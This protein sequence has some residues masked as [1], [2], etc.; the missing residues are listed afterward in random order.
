MKDMTTPIHLLISPVSSFGL[1]LQTVFTFAI[2]SLVL[3]PVLSLLGYISTNAAKRPIHTIV[4][5]SVL[6]TTAYFSI[7]DLSI[8]NSINTLSTSFYHDGS[9]TL[10]NASEWVRI[11]NPAEYPDALH[12]ASARLVFAGISSASVPDIPFTTNCEG[13]YEKDLLIPFNQLDSWVDSVSEVKAVSSIESQEDVWRLRK[14]FSWALWVKWNFTRLM[15]LIHATETFDLAVVGIAYLAMHYTFISLYISMQRLGS[16]FWLAT[17]IMLSSTFA[18][19]FAFVTSFYLGVPVSIVTLSEGLPFLVVTIGFGNKIRLTDIVLQTFNTRKPGSS[20][21]D[22]I[23]GVIVTEGKF[24]LRDYAIEI[25]ALIGG[26]SCGV[27]GLWQFCFLSVWI[28]IYD[29]LM[30]VTF[31]SA[32]LS[33]K[34]EIAKI[35]R[36]EA[37]RDALEEDGVS[38]KVAE[39]VAHSQSDEKKSNYSVTVFKVL[40]VS[41]F[42]LLNAVQLTNYP[43]N[44]ATFK[45]PSNSLSESIVRQVPQS[46]GG[47]VVTILPAFI[48]EHARLSARF[49]DSII[50]FLR[51]WTETIGD[52]LI[53]KFVVI[54]LALSVGLNAYLFNAARE[55]TVKIVEKIVEIEKKIPIIIERTSASASDSDENSEDADDMIEMKSSVKSKPPASKR[56][57]DESALFLKAGNA[58][59]LET[60]ELVNLAVSGKLPLY[61]LEKHLGD[62]TRAVAVR[63]AAV[64]RLS[65][66]KNLEN[67]LLPYEH[68]D[69]DRV[70]GACCENVVGYVPIP[71]GVAGPMTIDGKSY[72]LPMATTEGCLVAST[73]RGCKAM[74]AG[75]GVTTVLTNDGMT[76]GPCVSFAS[77]T[78]AGEAKIWLDSEEGQRTIKKAFNSTS[79]FARLQHIKTAMAGT[80]LFIRFTTTTGDAMGMNMISKGVEYSLKYM[81]EECGFEDMEI[82][83][84]SGNYCTDKKPASI[85]WIEG[86]GKSVVAEAIVPGHIVR[87][88]L[89]SDVDA[90]VELNI[91]KNLIGSAMAGSIGGFNAQASNL[92]TAIYLAT[93]QDPAQNVESSNC[94]TLMKNV[95]GNLHISVSMPSIEVGTIGGGTILEPQGAMLDLL[96]VRG[97]HPTSPGANSRQLARIVAAGVLAAEL[98][99][100][101]ALAAGHLVQSH[102]TH[103][104]SKAPTPAVASNADLKR[105]ADGSK[106]CIKS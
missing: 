80:L 86:R 66:T 37:I 99:L 90:M 74:N 98:S 26:A 51:R 15:D 14:S 2:M 35:K 61:A 21:K 89:K 97:P 38:Q 3:E 77:L 41:C 11:D 94:I 92:V 55:P 31:H 59:L 60:E 48:F 12:L 103:N 5:I 102:M 54:V 4:C 62:T 13:V 87:S 56:T 33:I 72:Y 88:V 71:V 105:L 93:G 40:M 9:H 83:S 23:S 19:M 50:L 95:D 8:P 64:S 82:I 7:L 49:E 57:L 58:K 16:T 36:N 67:S 81:V 52:P 20:I 27:N 84:V 45:A 32:I 29:L 53:S 6:A 85:N 101:A 100:C 63:R 1:D 78:R 24:I 22:L 18:F 46:A 76:R 39:S 34:I 69:F 73:M 96:G 28:L 65:I 75:G 47:T 104:R 79:R 43:I 91:S 106:I 70:L 68:Y 30:V 25:I 44:A 42:V 10:N 17:S